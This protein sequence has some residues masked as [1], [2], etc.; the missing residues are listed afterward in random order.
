MSNLY[1]CKKCTRKLIAEESRSHKCKELVDFK[2]EGDILLV[3]DGQ[4]WYPLNLKS[5]GNQHKE[6]N[7]R[8]NTTPFY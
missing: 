7:P 5:T 6:N 2:F 8:R 1:E 4:M 3:T